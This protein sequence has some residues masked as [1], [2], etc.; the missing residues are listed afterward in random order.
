MKINMT[1]TEANQI[2]RLALDGDTRYSHEA[3]G[4]DD[5][6]INGMAADLGGALVSASHCDSDVAIYDV[7]GEAVIVADANG[8]IAIRA[9][10]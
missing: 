1:Q 9:T 4:S 5:G 3:V 10:R 8:P 2:A 7:G 6:D